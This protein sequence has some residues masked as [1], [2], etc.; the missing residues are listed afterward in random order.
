MRVSFTVQCDD[1]IVTVSKWLACIYRN[2]DEF[3]NNTDVM[4]DL[5]T[6][7]IL[8]L[9]TGEFVAMSERTVFYPIMNTKMDAR[10]KGALPRA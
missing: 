8:P 10:R 5:H 4:N 1:H 2:L 9:A 6:L 3:D 7:K